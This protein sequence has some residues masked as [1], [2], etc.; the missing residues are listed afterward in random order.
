MLGHVVHVARSN[1]DFKRLS[2]AD[3]GGMKGLIAVGLWHG[4]IVLKTTV[5]GFP[6]TVNDSNQSVTFSVGL[7]DYPQGKEVIE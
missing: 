1:L 4:D 2:L 3:D 5:H 7:A 6:E